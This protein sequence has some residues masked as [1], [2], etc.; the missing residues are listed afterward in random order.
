MDAA[1]QQLFHQARTAAG[2]QVSQHIEALVNQVVVYEDFLVIDEKLTVLVQPSVPMPYR[3]RH[4]WF[5]GPDRAEVIDLPS[6]FH[7]PRAT[8]PQILGYLAL[9]DYWCRIIGFACS[10]RRIPAWKCTATTAWTFSGSCSLERT[11]METPDILPM[12][13]RRYLMVPTEKIKVINPRIRNEDQFQLNVQS[14]DNNGMLMPVRVNDKFLEKTGLYEL[15]CGKGRLIAHQRLGKPR[16]WPKCIPAP[17]RKPIIQSLVENLARSNPGTMVF[18]REL[19]QLHDE[20]WDYAQ[21][22]KLCCRSPDYVRQ[23]IGLVEKG[24][25][26]PDSGRRAEVLPSPSPSSL[27]QAVTMRNI[28]N[29]L[30]DAFDQG[31]CGFQTFARASRIVG[32]RYGAGIPRLTATARRNVAA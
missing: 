27:H 30:M 7:C 13:D 19:K 23:Y 17:A 16:S 10:A 22:G 12:K 28:Q 5:F 25:N 31:V 14:I 11:L 29:M 6:E 4:Y 3:V 26:P 2:N 18:A 1:F 21:I 9:P 15:I 24:E 20:N 8:R 32:A